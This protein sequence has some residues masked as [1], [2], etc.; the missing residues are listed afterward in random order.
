[1]VEIDA[2]K[3]V[4]PNA[5]EN[6]MALAQRLAAELELEE[7]DFSPT[8]IT[9]PPNT[10][11][12]NQEMKVR[13]VL[14]ELFIQKW[15]RI[16]RE[17]PEEAWEWPPQIPEGEIEFR[18]GEN[19]WLGGGNPDEIEIAKPILEILG[20][21][22]LPYD[23]DWIVVWELGDMRHLR[24][25]PTKYFG[26]PGGR[27]VLFSDEMEQLIEG[28]TITTLHTT[29]FNEDALLVETKEMFTI[30]KDGWLIKIAA[31]LTR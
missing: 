25:S 2:I 24:P 7:K 30:D 17:S 15:Q 23:W 8:A 14:R 16:Y 21:P 18:D 28:Q 4:L 9:F 12:E 13:A 26:M 11:F 20:G 19:D 22:D 1:M 29:N 6:Q 3:A 31:S 27:F 5:S 10:S